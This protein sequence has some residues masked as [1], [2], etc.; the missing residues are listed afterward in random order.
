VAWIESEV[1]EWMQMA[2]EAR[3]LPKPPA[4]K[5]EWVSAPAP[6]AWKTGEAAIAAVNVVSDG[7]AL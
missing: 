2:M 7:A 6:T 4:I 1:L 5:A 3:K